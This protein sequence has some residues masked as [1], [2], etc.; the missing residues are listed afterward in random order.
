MLIKPMTILDVSPSSQL[1]LVFHVALF[2]GTTV[3][4]TVLIYL[5]FFVPDKTEQDQY[6]LRGNVTKMVTLAGKP[7]HVGGRYFMYKLK[8]HDS[9]VVLGADMQKVGINFDYVKDQ[10]IVYE[11]KHSGRY[12]VEDMNQKGTFEIIEKENSDIDKIFRRNLENAE[13]FEFSIKGPY[14]RYRYLGDA[15]FLE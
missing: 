8:L 6:Y 1:A 13:A 12:P 7:H 11:P 5:W 10:D 9:T 14:G 3:L 4:S 2:V 15:T